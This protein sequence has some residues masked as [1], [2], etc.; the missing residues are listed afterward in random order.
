[1]EAVLNKN[2]GVVNDV[3]R[4]LNDKEYTPTSA[5]NLCNKLLIT[6][7]MATSNSSED[8][9]N[10]AEHFAFEISSYHISVNIQRIIDVCISVFTGVVNRLPKFGADGGTARENLALQNIQ[11]RLRMVMAYF[12][13]QLVLWTQNR[14]GGLLVL[15]SAN[16]DESLV[17]Y[18][19]KYDC[20]SADLNPIGM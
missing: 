10:R 2:Q 14:P 1:M 16:V 4:I 20:S 17:G 8:T 12:F 5:A 19:T 7:Y 13:A 15:G 9:R 3:R 18:M 6:C 11:A